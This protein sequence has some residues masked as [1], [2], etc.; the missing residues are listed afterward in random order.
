[1]KPKLYIPTD[2]RAYRV[3]E[4]GHQ[5]LIVD[6]SSEP[7]KSAREKMNRFIQEKKAEG[8]DIQD[9]REGLAKRV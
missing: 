5:E 6:F 7:K 3:T 4:T 9:E 2:Y 8:W 1:M